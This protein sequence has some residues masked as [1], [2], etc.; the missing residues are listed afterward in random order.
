MEVYH[1]A[2]LGGLLEQGL[3]VVDDRF[4]LV[5]FRNRPSPIAGGIGGLACILNFANITPGIGLGTVEVG[6]AV[7]LRELSTRRRL[8]APASPCRIR[9]ECSDRSS[10]EARRLRD[11]EV[12]F[13]LRRVVR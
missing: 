13:P 12:R 8:A 7:H 2:E 4:G 10:H 5:M 6:E 11:D 1:Q 9:S 3:V